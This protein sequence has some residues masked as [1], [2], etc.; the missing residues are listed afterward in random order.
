MK[1]EVT[2]SGVD[3]LDLEEDLN[4]IES[5]AKYS[6]N[7]LEQIEFTLRIK[8]PKNYEKLN[9]NLIK[10]IEI[11]KN[12]YIYLLGQYQYNKRFFQK[13]RDYFI[14]DAIQNVKLYAN[15]P[16]KT[17]KLIEKYKTCQSVLSI[18]INHERLD[19]NT[20]IKYYLRITVIIIEIIKNVSEELNLPRN[21]LEGADFLTKLPNENKL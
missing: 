8:F 17:Q 10:E 6:H 11:D 20:R 21:L 15:L 5:Q 2:I 16:D 12:E 4:K 7:S 3:I 1:K 18:V 19:N 14:Q 9:E 13:F